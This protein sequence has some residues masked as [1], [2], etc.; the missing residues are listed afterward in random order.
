MT[1]HRPF[2]D[3][4]KKLSPEGRARVAARVAELK[5]EMALAEL[6]QARDRKVKSGKARR[7]RT[8]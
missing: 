5:S 3:L 8:R 4:T 1:G 7:T 6:R 2:R